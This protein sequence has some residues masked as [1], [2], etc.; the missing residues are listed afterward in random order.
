MR[1]QKENKTAKTRLCVWPF[2][3]MKI[4]VPP[5]GCSSQVNLGGAYQTLKL[6]S[7][8]SLDTAQ[9]HLQYSALA[10]QTD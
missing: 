9:Q 5:G 6:T 3:H 8:T 2:C 7:H 1:F 4:G 10:A